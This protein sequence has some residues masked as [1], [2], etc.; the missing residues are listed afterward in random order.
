MSDYTEN[1]N[2]WELE[3][4]NIQGASRAIFN[5]VLHLV[6]DTYA[7]IIR[8]GGVVDRVE[9]DAELSDF[10]RV[11]RLVAQLQVL[12]PFPV[13]FLEL[14]VVVGQQS[15][16]LKPGNIGVH[17]GSLS[18]LAVVQIEANHSS[19]CVVRILNDL[20]QSGPHSAYIGSEYT[21]CTLTRLP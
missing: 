3:N 11:L 7:C 8:T 15:R 14:G 20:L 9:P 19:P 12:D 13:L 6:R 1:N 17:E 5:Y 18:V 16:S 21:Y 2:P 4:W 10:Q